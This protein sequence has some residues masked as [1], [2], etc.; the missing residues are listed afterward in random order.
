[1]TT[2]KKSGKTGFPVTRDRG[3][4]KTANEAAQKTWEPIYSIYNAKM[5]RNIR[6]KASDRD[7]KKLISA[8]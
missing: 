5:R 6:L 3:R 2:R 4:I 1:M 8:S 7:N